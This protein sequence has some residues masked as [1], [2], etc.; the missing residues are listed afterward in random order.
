MSLDY[1]QKIRFPRVD[2]DAIYGLTLIFNGCYTLVEQRK[3]RKCVVCH[4][5]YIHG[6]EYLCLV[7]HISIV[8]SYLDYLKYISF[9]SHHCTVGLS[10]FGWAV[11]SVI[12]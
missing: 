11:K 10:W 9:V 4:Q 1:V 6:W 8:F 7:G 5:S 2:A 3:G 12:H